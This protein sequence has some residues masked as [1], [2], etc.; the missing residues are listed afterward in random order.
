MIKTRPCIVISK[1]IK[2]RPNLVTVVPLS[3][4]PPNPVMPYHCEIEIE[5]ELPRRW[6]SRSCWVKGDMIY[7]LSFERVDLFNLGRGKDGRRVYQ[8]A[9]VSRDIFASVRKCVLS[10]LGM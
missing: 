1:P 3:T 4:T 8:T 6:S 5:F 7:S 2:H 10:G 9:T